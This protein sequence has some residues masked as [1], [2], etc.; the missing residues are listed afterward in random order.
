[1]AELVCV[2]VREVGYLLHPQ[3]ALAPGE[4]GEGRGRRV[5]VLTVGLRTGAFRPANW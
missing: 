4:G 5:D 2:V 3:S 1:M